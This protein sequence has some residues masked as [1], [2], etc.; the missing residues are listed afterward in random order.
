M[1]DIDDKIKAAA[2]RYMIDP[3]I[4]QGVSV[5][6]FT[7]G[8]NFMRGEI[9]RMEEDLATAVEVLDKMVTCEPEHLVMFGRDAAKDA[10]AKIKDDYDPTP[11]D[12][13]T[14]AGC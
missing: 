1:S 10:L 9:K 12:H 4:D 7:A 2:D 13:R 3:D 6:C 14:G 8:A 11:D 5:A